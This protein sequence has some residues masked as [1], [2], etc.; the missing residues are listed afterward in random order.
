MEIAKASSMG[1]SEVKRIILSVLVNN[2]WRVCLIV[3]KRSISSLKS[4][5][6][7]LA[8]IKNLVVMALQP[9]SFAEVQ[10][11]YSYLWQF[12]SQPY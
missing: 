11:E 5:F 4:N 2:I 8:S 1:V 12:I 7:S 9:Q 6:L 3:R 10:G